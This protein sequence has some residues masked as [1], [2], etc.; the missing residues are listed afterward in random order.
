[1]YYVNFL[2]IF[3]VWV[4]SS[5]MLSRVAVAATRRAVVP[6]I[7]AASVRFHSDAPAM[8]VEQGG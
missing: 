6:R 7:V 4:R 5:T 2:L 8:S 3:R 1:M